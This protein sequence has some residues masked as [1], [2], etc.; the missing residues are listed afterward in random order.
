MRLKSS[1]D[2]CAEGI[3]ALFTNVKRPL[4]GCNYHRW[5]D[6]AACEEERSS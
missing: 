6:K 4:R 1:D 2:H 5:F 3:R